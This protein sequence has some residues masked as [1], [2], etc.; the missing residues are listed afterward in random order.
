MVIR[1]LNLFRVLIFEFRTFEEIGVSSSGKTQ[2][3]G[4]WIRRFES[5]HPSHFFSSAEA[6]RNSEEGIFYHEEKR[7]VQRGRRV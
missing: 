3:F 7:G 2:V 4:T 6:V 5:S 1:I